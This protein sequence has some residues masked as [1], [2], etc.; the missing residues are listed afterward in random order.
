MQNV[1][2]ININNMELVDPACISASGD[3]EMLQ[4]KK[5]GWEYRGNRKYYYRKRRVGKKVLS[6]YIG[7]GPEAE[8]I[9]QE[10]ERVKSQRNNERLAWKRRQAEIRTIDDALDSIE[11]LTRTI[12]NS[13]LLLAGYHTH[14]G[15]WRKKRHG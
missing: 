3:R 5:M 4:H 8:K 13:H 9:V 6:E 1:Y 11:R 12:I 15:E 7:A 14:R 10:D 2:K